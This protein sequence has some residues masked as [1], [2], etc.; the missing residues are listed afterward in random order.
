MAKFL[1]SDIE[2]SREEQA[3]RKWCK[4]NEIELD[5]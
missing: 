3:L 1:F 4:E 5:G 2:N